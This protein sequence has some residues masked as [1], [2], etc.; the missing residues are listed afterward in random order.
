MEIQLLKLKRINCLRVSSTIERYN[1]IIA[2]IKWI[3]PEIL[4][5]I[6][7]KNSTETKSNEIGL[8]Q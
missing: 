6:I 5:V 2:I 8:T 7:A 1:T 3:N 4:I